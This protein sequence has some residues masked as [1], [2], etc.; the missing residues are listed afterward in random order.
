MTTWTA[1]ELTA[2][3]DADELRIAAPARATTL[4][5]RPA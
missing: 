2:I 1:G 3:A 4:R 5:L